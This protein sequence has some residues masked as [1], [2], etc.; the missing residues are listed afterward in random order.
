MTDTIELDDETALA[1]AAT[2]ARRTLGDAPGLIAYARSLAIPSLGT[3]SDGMPRA[4]SK[5]APLPFRAD[6]IDDTDDA[7]ARLIQWVT[8]WSDRLQVNPP[9]TVVVVW[10]RDG[11]EQGFRA[12]ATPAGAG[13]LVQILVTWLLIRWEQILTDS[14]GP[15]FVDDVN[16][17]FRTLFGK[18]PRAPRRPRD[19]NARQCPVCGE[20]AVGAV[21]LS[22][23]V[24][25]VRVQCEAC[26]Y[27]IPTKTYRQVLDWI[28]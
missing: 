23:E 13:Q 12:E 15:V 2:R 10:K 17:I 6:A 26:S 4:A 27:E 5:E 3:M 18:Y 14:A 19:V 20:H 25:D 1:L 11:E 16:D 8:N 22:E 7:Y 28:G 21:W 24:H 9:A